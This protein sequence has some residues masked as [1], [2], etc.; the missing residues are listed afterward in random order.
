MGT[1]LTRWDGLMGMVTG[2][3]LLIWWF[4]VATL[5]PP[6]NAGLDLQG[7]VSNSTWMP[8]NVPGMMAAILLPAVITSLYVAQKGMISKVGQV[9]FFLS[10]LGTVM[11]AWVQ[12]EQTVVW[13]RLLEESP[14]LVDFNGPMFRDIPFAL[15]YWSGH[16]FL[17]VGL[18]LF[19]RATAR[20]GAFPLWAGRLLW[21]GGLMFGISGVLVW[22]R[23]LAILG[24]APALMWMG[25]LQWRDR[26]AAY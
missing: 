15:T 9:G 3:L 17:G 14:A 7:M 21:L 23:F 1:Q 20:A 16:G 26:A 25:Y 18:L 4:P 12:I 22:L 2:G 6:L 8:Y 13:P 10:L 24:L 19:G 5:V 11:F